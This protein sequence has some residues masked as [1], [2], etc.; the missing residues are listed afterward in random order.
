MTCEEFEDRLNEVLDERRRP[1]WDAPLRMHGHSCAACRELAASYG[2]ML[3]GLHALPTPEPAADLPVRVL[4]RLYALPATRRRRTLMAAALATAAAL[5]VAV[6][7]PL[8]FGGQGARQTAQVAAPQP[9]ALADVDADPFAGFYG[10]PLLGPVLTAIRDSDETTDP[11]AELAK[12]T[13]QGLATVVLRMPGIGLQGFLAPAPNRLGGLSMW[14]NQ[15]SEELRPVTES[16][17]E[18]LNLL[19]RVFPVMDFAARS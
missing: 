12:G 1:E 9:M 5:M 6:Q 11:Y 16:M 17:T 10:L 15:V 14:P 18:T 4:D 19:M 13:G 8:Q 3:D 2:V 7:L